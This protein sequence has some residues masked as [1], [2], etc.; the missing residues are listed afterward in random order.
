MAKNKL[1]VLRDRRRSENW[2]LRQLIDARKQAVA[3]PEEYW[4][5]LYANDPNPNAFYISKTS[6]IA[7][8]DSQILQ[9]AE[10]VSKQ[11]AA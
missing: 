3:T 2:K 10:T 11:E 4:L 1:T 7:W 9:Q 6:F 5:E 8:I